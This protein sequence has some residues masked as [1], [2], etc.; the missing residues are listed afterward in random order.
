MSVMEE[1]R[2][3]AYGREREFT[4][5]E[6][7]ALMGQI[8]AAIARRDNETVGRLIRDLPMD[9][10]VMMAFASTLGKEFILDVGY[11]LTQA[12][13]KFGEGWLDAL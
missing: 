5:E 4:K 2:A 10:N 8:D 9:A 11:D 6:Y 7:D 12:N 13:M 1:R 3:Y